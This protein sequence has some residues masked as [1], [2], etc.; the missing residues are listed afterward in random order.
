[1][2][3]IG[4]EG[5]HTILAKITLTLQNSKPPKDN[6]PRNEWIA[7]ETSQLVESIVILKV[8]QGRT[9]VILSPIYVKYEYNNAKNFT[10]A[11]ETF[12]LKMMK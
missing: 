5:D 2:K 8:Y 3:D 12:P 1:M 7:L 9:T 11:S 4:K 6:I 10:A